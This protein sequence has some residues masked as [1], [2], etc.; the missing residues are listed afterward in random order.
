MIKTLKLNHLV[1]HDIRYFL[2]FGFGAGLMPYAPGTFGTLVA[3][4][5]Y[6]LLQFCTWQYYL[7]F[8]FVAF[9]VGVQL[10]HEITIELNQPDYPGIVW[11]EC[12]GYWITM[13][14]V[15]FDLKWIILGFLLF[16]FF[17]ILKPPPIRQL[18]ERL[19][20]G[21]GVMIDDVIAGVMAWCSLQLIIWMVQ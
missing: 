7:A 2:A 4:P 15:P 17:D 5:I 19:Q 10:C 1:N 12:V 20:N 8:V 11:D 6:L 21:F 3:I 18:D 16:R 14:L 13:F 9:W